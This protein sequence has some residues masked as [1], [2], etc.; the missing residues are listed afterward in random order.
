[1]KNALNTN[2]CNIF[3]SFILQRERCSIFITSHLANYSIFFCDFAFFVFS[4]FLILVLLLRDLMH[5]F[6][7]FCSFLLFLCNFAIFTLILRYFAFLLYF[8]C[9]FANL[10]SFL[11]NFV[12]FVLILHY[13]D[14]FHHALLIFGSYSFC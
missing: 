6:P 1:M 2:E 7:F 3:V 8:I 11:F 14:I 4:Q 12:D 13:F 5:P 10:I 9:N